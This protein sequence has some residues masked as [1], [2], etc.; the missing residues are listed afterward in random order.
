MT[1]NILLALIFSLIPAL[2][3]ACVIFFFRKL[4]ELPREKKDRANAK[5]VYAHLMSDS[6]QYTS[7]ASESV[8]VTYCYT[9]QGRN[10]TYSEMCEQARIPE[11]IKLYYDPEDPEHAVPLNYYSSTKNLFCKCLF[12]CYVLCAFIAIM[13]LIA[14]L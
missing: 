6:V 5:M 12:M 13:L 14:D 10:Y 9:V 8:R 4:L 3:L 11:G 2:P 7:S 1:L